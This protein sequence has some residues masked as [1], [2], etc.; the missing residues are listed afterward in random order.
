MNELWQPRCEAGELVFIRAGAAAGKIV[1][2]DHR[3]RDVDGWP[4]WRVTSMGGPL[5]TKVGGEM[6]ALQSAMIVDRWLIPIRIEAPPSDHGAPAARGV[7]VRKG[8]STRG[9]V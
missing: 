6:L 3:E 9:A 7:K 2:V 8:R 4:C 1:R 5:P